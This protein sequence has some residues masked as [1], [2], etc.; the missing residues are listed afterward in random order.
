MI[1][2]DEA[3]ALL[4]SVVRTLGAEAVPLAGAAGRVLAARI[5][6]RSD[7]PRVP[8]AAMD[9]YAVLDASTRPGES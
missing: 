8:V 6:A 3:L 4:E 5:T 9:G 1:T 2:F 7:S